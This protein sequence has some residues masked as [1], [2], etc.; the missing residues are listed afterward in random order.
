[1][2]PYMT[3]GFTLVETLVVSAILLLVMLGITLFQRD[4]FYQ[5]SV[6][7][8]TLSTIQ[9]ARSILKTMVKELRSTSQAG[10]GSYPILTAATDTLTFYS[11][12]NSDGT[13]DRVRYFLASS[14]LYRGIIMASGTPVTY[15]P[16]YET[17]STLAS[18][19][20]NAASSTAIF[21]YFDG[22]YNGTSS[23][24]TQPVFVSAIRNVRITLILDADQN[25]S[26]TQ[27]TYVT[28]VTLR[29]LKDNL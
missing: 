1:M 21:D 19:V 13:K 3:K 7:S 16:T 9:D 24:L 5:N 12:I 10:D 2:Y 22:T 17:I 6:Q 28:D 14:T 26:P 27:R 8:G 18:G 4:I 25:K 20:R 15:N 23:P 11:D 29:N